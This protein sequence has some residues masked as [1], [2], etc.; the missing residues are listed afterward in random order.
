MRI[1]IDVDEANPS[2]PTGTVRRSGADETAF[3]GWVELLRVLEAA[4]QPPGGPQAARSQ[5]RSPGR[6]AR[7]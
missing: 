5:Q 7:D 2:P 4:L 1:T 6:P 3:H